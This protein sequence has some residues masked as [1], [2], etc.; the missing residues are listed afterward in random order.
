MTVSDPFAI[1]PDRG[2]TE[3]AGDGSLVA[4]RLLDDCHPWPPKAST[5]TPSSTLAARPLRRRRLR[6]RLRASSISASGSGGAS[7]SGGGVG[8]EIMLPQKIDEAIMTSIMPD[9]KRPDTR[10]HVVIMVVFWLVP[11]RTTA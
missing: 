3:I 11:C 1:K 6:L 9:V 4:T 2:L 8:V 5:V 10:H 7:T